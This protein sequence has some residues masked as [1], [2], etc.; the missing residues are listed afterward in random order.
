VSDDSE[1]VGRGQADVAMVQAARA[2]DGAAFGELYARWIDRV[3]DVARNIVRNPDTADEVAQDAFVTAWQQLDRLDAPEAFGGWLLRITRNRAL[4]RL[5]RENRSRPMDGAVVTDLHDRGGHDPFAGRRGAGDTSDVVADLER[6][7]LIDAAAVALGERDASLLDLHLRHGLT[8]AEIAD[9]LGVTPNAAHQQ[10]F[11]MRARL[12]STIGSLVLWRSGRPQCP[13]L[14]QLVPA[15]ERFDAA[16]ARIVERHQRTC[17]EC[18][19]RRALLTSPTEL[20]A[21][22]PIAVL[23]LGAKLD[24][25]AAV[26]SAGVPLGEPPAGLTPDPPDEV[27]GDAPGDVPGGR[28]GDAQSGA[29]PSADPGAGRAVDSDIDHDRSSSA[30][31]DERLDAPTSI[32]AVASSSPDRTAVGP[33][34]ESSSE[35]RGWWWWAAA[36]LLLIVAITSISMAVRAATRESGTDLAVATSVEPSDDA[37]TGDA[38]SGTV[39][40]AD[41]L[42]DAPT[43]STTSTSVSTTATTDPGLAAETIAPL[44]TVAAPSGAVAT[45]PPNSLR[46]PVT[47]APPAPVTTVAPAP[48]TT[49]PTAPATTAPTAPA[50]TNPQTAPTTTAPAPTTTAPSTTTTTLPPPRIVSFT[51][52]PGSNSLICASPTA[53]PRE[54]NW[55]STLGSSATLTTDGV[56]R[57]VPLSGP[58]TYCATSGSTAT[59]VVANAGGSVQRSLAL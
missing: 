42:A 3:H 36:A 19:D 25:F 43:S 29:D 11:R 54:F 9:E 41:D 27:P 49:A 13:T 59:L 50:S 5:A 37:T 24:I 47:A 2:G 39:R 45:N 40:A 15:G 56:T 46:P 7:D 20:F 52:T 53:S 12:G 18:T 31:R 16:T 34:D 6:D 32:L 23:P 26:R 48:P 10:L 22:L 1:P 58:R 8:P 17:T 44:D 55:S 4:D 51:W 28:P 30:D 57:S 14:A 21:A 35:R 38:R 33:D